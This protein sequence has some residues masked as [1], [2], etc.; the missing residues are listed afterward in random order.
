M[1]LRD[2]P[3]MVSKIGTKNWPPV[4][5]TTRKDET[6]RPIGEIGTLQEA[7][8]HQGIADKVF[9]R[10]RFEGRSYMG[11]LEFGD[12]AFCS[13]VHSVLQHF[14]RHPM[15]DVGDIDLPDKP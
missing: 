11:L 10:M 2:H 8:M 14:L 13:V 4:W 3:Q 15:A 7:L 9:L 1:K 6:T 12:S 5:T